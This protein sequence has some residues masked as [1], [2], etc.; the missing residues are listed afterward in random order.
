MEILSQ[1]PQFRTK[2]MVLAQAARF[3]KCLEGNSRFLGVEITESTRAKS[4]K[5]WFVAFTPSNPERVQAILDRQQD[6]RAQRAAEQTF[7][8][9]LDKDG[10]RPF[11][12]CYSHASGETYEVDCQGRSCSCPDHEFRCKPNGLKC[13][14][15]IAAAAAIQAGDV[16]TW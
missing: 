6:A 14:H 3:A 2:C 7:S 15:Q 9:M 4:D 1:V 13:K 10:G 12:W 5:R 8:F 11:L 16:R